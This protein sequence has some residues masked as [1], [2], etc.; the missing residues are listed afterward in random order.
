MLCVQIW[1]D[2]EAKA[3]STAVS[4]FRYHDSLAANIRLVL[5]TEREGFERQDYNRL[6]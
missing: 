2:E 4:V 3:K 6:N 5:S 1:K